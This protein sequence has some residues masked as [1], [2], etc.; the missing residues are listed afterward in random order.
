[1]LHSGIAVID[2]DDTPTL[3]TL[4]KYLD[5]KCF[6]FTKMDSGEIERVKNKERL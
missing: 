4:A 3:T 1:M 2:A 6:G 5:R